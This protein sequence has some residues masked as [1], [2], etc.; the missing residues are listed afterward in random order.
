MT[1]EF[2][3]FF[4]YFVSLFITKESK[5]RMIYF[6]PSLAISIRFEC[7]LLNDF[8]RG[9]LFKSKNLVIFLFRDFF[10]KFQIKKSYK[11]SR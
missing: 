11:V 7:F 4:D 1:K 3:N 8:E 2:V 10:G 6:C 5:Y 9:N